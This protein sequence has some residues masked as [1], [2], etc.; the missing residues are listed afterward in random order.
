MRN[1]SVDI[2]KGLSIIAVVLT[3]CAASFPN[4]GPIRIGVLLGGMWHV[5]VFFVVAGFFLKEEK[6]Q[7]PIDFTRHK[8]ATLYFKLLCFY[9]PAVLLHNVFLRSGLYEVNDP[10]YFG[11]VMALYSTKDFVIKTLETILLAGREPIMGAMWFAYVLFMALIGYSLVSFV[12]GK[13]LKENKCWFVKGLVLF[14]LTFVSSVL[15]NMYSLTLNRCSNIFAAMF[16]IYLGQLLNVHLKLKYNSWLV[17]AAAVIMFLHESI[18]NGSISL[19]N[20]VYKGCF[21]LAVAG[22]A[23]TYM[24]MFCANKISSNFL[25]RFLAKIGEYSFSI[26]ALQFLC[27][28]PCTLL[29]NYLFDYSFPIGFLRPHVG[30]NYL[31]LLVYLAFGTLL[32]VCLA[33][34]FEKSTSFFKG[35]RQ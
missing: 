11:K 35:K 4:V 33:I 5:P 20:N 17:F 7:K 28:K 1:S 16:L 3:H 15:T 14:S 2:V 12:I 10:D 25:G 9:I 24:F 13:F 27:F 21:H 26:M 22:G 30:N 29:L 18:F 19:N 31:C 32:P 34:L 8:I 6:L 23:G